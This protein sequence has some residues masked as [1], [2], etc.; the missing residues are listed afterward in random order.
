[1]RHNTSIK[2][3]EGSLLVSRLS[4]LGGM[5]VDSIS[6]RPKPLANRS[7]KLNCYALYVVRKLI[8]ICGVLNNISSITNIT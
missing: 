2:E 4:L 8:G 1:M 3:V 6:V 7:N 5:L